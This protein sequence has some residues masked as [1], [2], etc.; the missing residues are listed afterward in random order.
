MPVTVPP[1]AQL[2]APASWRTVDFIADLHLHAQDEATF[3]AWQHYLAHTSADAVFILGDLFELWV[4]DDAVL[5]GG[6]PEAGADPFGARCAQ[7][8][9][10]AAQ[11][12]KLFFMHG[13]RDFLVGQA[14]LEHCQTQFL[15]DPSVLEFGAQRWLLTHGDA[16]CLADTDYQ[17]FRQQVRNPAWQQEFLARPL[18]QRQSTARELRRHSEQL[19][20]GATDYADVDAG[21]AR[22]WLTAAQAQ[23]M[24]HGHTHRPAVHALGP[25]QQ[26]WVLSDWDCAGAAARAQVLRLTLP[27]PEGDITPQRVDLRC[28]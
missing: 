21:A 19:K 14:F 22:T 15:P 24:I 5:E 8:L 6:A 11:H 10:S 28:R 16:L 7:V 26:R 9:R 23:S 25:G 20:S 1:L 3:E 12:T 13:N 4:G 17:R 2:K 27:L 18:A